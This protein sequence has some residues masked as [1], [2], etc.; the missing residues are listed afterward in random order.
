MDTNVVCRFSWRPPYGDPRRSVTGDL[1]IVSA[2]KEKKRA[3]Y[4]FD[5][6]FFQQGFLKAD[7][8]PMSL[9][10]AK[11]WINSIDIRKWVGD[12]YALPLATI[13]FPYEPDRQTAGEDLLVQLILGFLEDSDDKA[14]YRFPEREIPLDLL[15]ES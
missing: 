3:K 5:I 1:E 7:M 14:A 12:A 2:G 13:L 4:S 6:V 11:N 9:A 15:E 10:E 8:S